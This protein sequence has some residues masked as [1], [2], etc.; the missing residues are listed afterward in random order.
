MGQ[1]LFSVNHSSAGDFGG[2]KSS[3]N[4]VVIKNQ[5]AGGKANYFT[6]ALRLRLEVCY[7]YSKMICSVAFS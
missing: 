6:S 3:A 2:S 5:K 4:E 7:S 1:L